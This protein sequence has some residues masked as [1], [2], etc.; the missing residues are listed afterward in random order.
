MYKKVFVIIFSVLLIVFTTVHAFGK[1]QESWEDSQLF[2]A[3]VIDAKTQEKPLVGN[4]DNNIKKKFIVQILTAKILNGPYEGKLIKLSN[5]IT[6][7]L[8][9]NFMLKP[10]DEVIVSIKDGDFENAYIVEFARDKKLIYLA[11]LFILLMI[12]IGGRKGIK[13][14]FSLVIT[15]SLIFYILLPYIFKGYDPIMITVI[16]A[17][18]VTIITLIIIGGIT[19]KTF[20]A[21]IGTT[22]GVVVA[23]ILALLVGD[24][25]RLTGFDEGEM[26]LLLQV[27]EQINFDYRGILFAGMIIGALGAVM[28]VGVSIASAVE[29]IKKANPYL[30]TIRLIQVGMNV[31]RDIMGT[32]SNTLIL[33]YTGGAI[34]LM[35]VFMTCDTPWL[36]IINLETIAVEIVRALAG[37][38]GIIVAI[39]ITSIAAGILFS[40]KTPSR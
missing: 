26:R 25:A 16:V 30:G 2:R 24:M 5:M 7:H 15:I 12:F 11:L 13:S 29:E 20:S 4:D 35:I 39:P 33:A 17:V 1:Q 23:G 40:L 8:D 27:S 14:L 6:N 19:I 36:R 31:G 10:S 37:S 9:Y 28:D 22:G 21:F 32:M 18:G 3:V 34:P 38:I